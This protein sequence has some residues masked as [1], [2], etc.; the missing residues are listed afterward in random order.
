MKECLIQNVYLL[1]MYI[2]QTG[3]YRVLHDLYLDKYSDEMSL[4]VEEIADDIRDFNKKVV[5]VSKSDHGLTPSDSPTFVKP[6]SK[7]GRRSSLG[8]R[9]NNLSV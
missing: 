6:L 4:L 3:V 7:E 5:K 2:F 9:I 1:F 8:K